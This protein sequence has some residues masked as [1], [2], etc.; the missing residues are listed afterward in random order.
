MFLDAHNHLH[1]H[2]LDP[3]RAGIMQDLDSLC[4][5]GAVV[6]G[7]HPDDWAA[8]AVLAAGYQTILPA[9]GIHPWK[10]Q[11]VPEDW[12]TT[13]RAL[14]EKDPH[15][16][17]GEV[18]L[19]R[20]VTG[21]DLPKQQ[22]FFRRQLA[23]ATEYRRP[24]TIHCIRAWGALLETLEAVELPSQGFL[25]H[26]YA[27]PAEMTRRF[28]ELGARFSFSPYF[29]HERKAPQRAVFAAL[30]LDRIL[31]ETD[32][33][34]MPPPEV[35]GAKL[36]GD[37]PTR[38]SHPGNIQLAYEA[39]AQ[40]RGISLDELQAMVRTNFHA[41]FGTFALQSPSFSQKERYP[42]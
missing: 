41:L 34:D 19:D 14:L 1:D 18:G 2:R 40:L 16:S 35:S 27:G 7:T 26:A 15:A 36:L 3:W 9:Y 25:L 38:W 10:I 13:L 33:P 12:E 17:V 22:H 21:H 29:L 31:V 4:G 20:W 39:L 32:A 37:P 6:N 30:P 28:L 24:V 5:W 23:L 8:V 11:D 42:A